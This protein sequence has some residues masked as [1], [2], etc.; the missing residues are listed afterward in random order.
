MD[1]SKWG[2]NGCGNLKG[3][4]CTFFGEELEK[5]N[6]CPEYKYDFNSIKNKQL[7]IINYYGVDKQLDQLVEEC[8]ELIVAIAKLKRYGN[9]ASGMEYACSIVEEI[10]DVENLIEQLK[11]KNAHIA[12]GV[13]RSKEFKV[14]RELDRISKK[15]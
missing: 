6:Y 5:D 13:K 2:C 1:I 4:Y 9:T 12:E 14:D 7:S 3:R 8:G 10:A 11:F 15:I